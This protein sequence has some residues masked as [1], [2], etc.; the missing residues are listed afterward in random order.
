MGKQFYWDPSQGGNGHTYEFVNNDVTWDQA[1]A[2]ASQ[3][4]LNGQS[5]YLVTVTS[6][7]ELSFIGSHMN[8]ISVGWDAR[9]VW[10][11]ATCLTSSPMGQ[12]IMIA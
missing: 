4:S 11:G 5:G 12:F 6:S 7:A 9:D 3:K 2:L 8:E 1:Y 10:I